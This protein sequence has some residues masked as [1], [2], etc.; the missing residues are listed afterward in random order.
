M[1]RV[2]C[3]VEVHCSVFDKDLFSDDFI[4]SGSV[5]VTPF[6]GRSVSGKTITCPL[7]NA[8]Q[9]KAAGVLTLVLDSA[10]VDVELQ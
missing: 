4:G 6:V 1:G 3:K 9:K 8:K 2:G 10:L 5:D 7:A